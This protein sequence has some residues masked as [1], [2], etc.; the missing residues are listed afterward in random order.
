MFKFRE[1]PVYDFQGL[2]QSR[3]QFLK[4]LQLLRTTTKHITK[5]STVSEIN[6]R[7]K[8]SELISKVMLDMMNCV[9]SHP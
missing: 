4:N 3:K 2:T 6:R 7:A 5:Y 1:D 9:R 8:L